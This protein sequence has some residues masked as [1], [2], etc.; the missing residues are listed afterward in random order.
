MRAANGGPPQHSFGFEVAGEGEFSPHLGDAVGPDDGDADPGSGG[1]GQGGHV[2]SPDNAVRARTIDPYPVP[3]IWP[4]I[5]W[6]PTVRVM[7]FMGAFG[8]VHD[9]SVSVPEIWPAIF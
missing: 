2:C 4:A 7:V 9:R 3:E 1:A 8:A 5:F 6:M